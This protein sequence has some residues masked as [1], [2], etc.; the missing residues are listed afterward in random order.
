MSRPGSQF[1]QGANPRNI[2]SDNRVRNRISP[3]HMKSGKAASDHDALLPHTVVAS[4]LP[5]GMP[6]PANCMPAH[7]VAIRATAIQTPAPSSSARNPSR[8]AAM[9]RS[10]MSNP[11]LHGAFDD[12]L[13]ALRLR[14]FV[15][16]REAAQ[17]MDQFIDKS[18]EQNHEAA[19]VAELRNPQRHRDHT[20]RNVGKFKRLPG[21]DRGMPR[22]KADEANAHEQ[23]Y[24]LDIMSHTIVEA[25]DQEA[26]ADHL[27]MLERVR[28]P[29][30]GRRRHAPGDEII[31]RRNIDAER[32]AAGQQHHQHEN[33]DEEKPGEIAGEK[34]EP[35]KKHADH[36]VSFPLARPLLRKQ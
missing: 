16:R 32:P 17:D 36:T 23:R 27:A 22:E 5:A 24:D 6:P 29:E 11:A 3:I 26:D 9:E 28:E 15:A 2:S 19:A 25:V 20:L 12:F 13:G 35:I 34:V 1:S 4:T 30:K 8:I 14:Q 18:D 7:P 10:S 31:A 21:H 33:R